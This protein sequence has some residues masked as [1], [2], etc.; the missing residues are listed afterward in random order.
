MTPPA[1]GAPRRRAGAAMCAL[2][3]CAWC[4]WASAFPRGSP[5]AQ[6]TWAVSLGIV[7]VACVILRRVALSP[8]AHPMRG[9]ASLAPW[10]ALIAVV[11]A[12]EVLGIDTG[13]HQAHLTISALARAFRPLD[14]GLLLVW[15]L[16]GIGYPLALRTASSD[17]TDPKATDPN[18]TDPNTTDVPDMTGGE[19][20]P[21]SLGIAVVPALL[22]PDN[23]P[24]GVAFWVVVAATCAGLSGVSRMTRGR[25]AGA[26]AFVETVSRPRI[27]RVLLV[28]GWLFAGWHLF[29]H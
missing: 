10:W 9:G 22:L 7:S 8:N 11:V 2:A 14:A 24:V 16:V 12:W 19:H 27:V 18:T 1:A 25:V 28:A 29:A 3:L 5:G 13:T 26:A 21:S 20:P 15:M 23:R 4:G 6:V 17:A